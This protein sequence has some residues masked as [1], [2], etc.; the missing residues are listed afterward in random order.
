M[1]YE[2]AVW[3]IPIGIAGGVLSLVGPEVGLSW[4]EGLIR[5]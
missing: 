4:N 1:E 5:S 2:W 3:L